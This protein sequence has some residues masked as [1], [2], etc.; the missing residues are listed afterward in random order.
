MSRALE[1]ALIEE[2]FK[3]VEK[4]IYKCVHNFISQHGGDFEELKSQS[5]LAF[6]ESYKK[7]KA[8]ENASFSTWMTNQIRFS[9]I[10]NRIKESRFSRYRQSDAI[11][12]SYCSRLHEILTDL[13]E[14]AKTIVNLIFET[15]ADLM[16]LIAKENGEMKKVKSILYFYLKNNGWS[17]RKIANAYLQI[18]RAL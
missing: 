4:L 2:T 5:F 13:E 18:R 8:D 9:L 10:N 17:R 3:D 15:P 12:Q 1:K 11:R 7:Y 6:M 14:D 16:E